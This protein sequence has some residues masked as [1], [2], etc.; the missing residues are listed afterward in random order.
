VPLSGWAAAAEEDAVV[1]KRLADTVRYLASDELEGRA[2]KTKGIDLA[3]DYIA[4][5]FTQLGLKTDLFDGTPMQS[6]SL[7]S[8]PKIR[9]EEKPA[10]V[11]PPAPNG[12]G[13]QPAEPKP[14]EDSTPTAAQPSDLQHQQA[15]FKNVV[16]VLEGEGPLAEQT[17]VVGA[18]YDHLGIRGGGSTLE[19]IARSLLAM[20]PQNPEVYNG[21]DDNASGVAALIE[22]ARSLANRPEKLRRRVVFVAFTAEERGLLGSAYYV[23][24]SPFPLDKTVAM[25][26]L[27]MLGRLRDERLIVVGSGTGT[28]FGEVLDQVNQ[29]YNLKLDKSPRGFGGSDHASFRARK[30]PAMHFFTGTHENLHR[31]TD[32]LETLN[33]PGMRRLSQFVGE[34]VVA[35]ANAEQRPEYVVPGKSR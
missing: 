33:V 6:F 19:R 30:I 29:R 35:L 14:G 17:I 34:V 24:H 23:S 32:D 21:A 8:P 10:P 16:A 31:P 15:E 22:I 7:S 20:P 28:G 13:P 18:H 4:R 1:E 2:V 9:P 26:N 3:A 11:G 27:D 25:L 5:Q 12:K